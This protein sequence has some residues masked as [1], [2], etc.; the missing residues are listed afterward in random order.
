MS[1]AYKA[2]DVNSMG[3][4]GYC[5]T[6]LVLLKPSNLAEPVEILSKTIIYVSCEGF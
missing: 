3:T 5:V 4:N 1:E 2:T 6:R